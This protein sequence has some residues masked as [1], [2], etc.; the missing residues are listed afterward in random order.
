MDGERVASTI[1]VVGGLLVLALTALP[2]AFARPGQVGTYYAA[3]PAGPAFISLISTV[4]AITLLSAER[5]RSD[6][7]L[8]SGIAVTVSA[9]AVVLALLW[10]VPAGDIVSGIE[11]PAWF[12]YHPASLVVATLVLLGASGAYARDVL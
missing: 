6:P 3:G 4:A 2:Y 9:F 1:G 7:A 5:G 8:A 10:A 11:V 12:S